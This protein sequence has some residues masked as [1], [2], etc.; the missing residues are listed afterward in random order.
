[1]FNT[2]NALSC[3][4]QVFE[5]EHALQNLEAFTSLNGPRFYRLP[6]NEARVKLVRSD[7]PVEFPAKVASEDG[8]LT[9]FDPG[10]PLYWSV[11]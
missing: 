4:A 10:F 6:A 5:E 1:M 9:V 8:S 3:V 7:A 2:L 11:Q